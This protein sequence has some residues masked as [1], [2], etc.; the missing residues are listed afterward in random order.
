LRERARDWK[1]TSAR[2]SESSETNECVRGR[3]IGKERVRE[4]AREWIESGA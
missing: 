2:E 4:R 1:E 3:E